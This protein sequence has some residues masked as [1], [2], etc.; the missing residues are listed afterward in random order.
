MP[1]ER[2]NI[3]GFYHPNPE[4]YGSSKARGGNFMRGDVVGFDEEANAMDPQ[5]RIALE[6]TYEGLENG[7]A[8]QHI[9]VLPIIAS[10]STCDKIVE[11][12]ADPDAILASHP[13]TITS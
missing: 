2:Y 7:M 10:L 4:R 12:C 5:Q 8:A 3:D 11:H 13:L 1:K 6:L 9:S